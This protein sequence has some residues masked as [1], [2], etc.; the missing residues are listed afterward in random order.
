MG[1]AANPGRDNGAVLVADEVDTTSCP[2]HIGTFNP[3][4]I[5]KKTASVLDLPCGVWGMAETQA[6]KQTFTNF[7]KDIKFQGKLQS[8]TIRSLHGAFAPLRSSSA[9]AGAWT[10]VGF[11]ADYTLRPLQLPWKSFEFL[12]GRAVAAC[13][14]IGQNHLIGACV[15]A[16]PNGPTYGTT[17]SLCED[18][19][20]VVSSNIVYGASGFR[21]VCGDFNR[22]VWSLSTF[23]QWRA[24]GWEEAQVI[25]E[26]RFGCPRELQRAPLSL[27]TSG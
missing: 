18:L 6:T 9:T 1:E 25:A 22:D 8:R 16:P 4:G 12:S 27:T 13:S 21:F 17:T 5:S 11:V 20:D 15:Y 24:A 14:L 2:L 10:G 26:N 7:C 19:L 3:T 23:D